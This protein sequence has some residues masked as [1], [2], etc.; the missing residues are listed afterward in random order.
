[1]NPPEFGEYKKDAIWGH[2]LREKK[3]VI[4]PSINCA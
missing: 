4:R 1:M 3:P 2:F